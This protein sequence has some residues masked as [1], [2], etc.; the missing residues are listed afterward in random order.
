MDDIQVTQATET[1]PN[2]LAIRV[3]VGTLVLA[4]DFQSLGVRFVGGIGTD[5][6]EIF[7]DTMTST[8]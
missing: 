3:C 4:T 8:S 2:Q 7:V 1:R 5:Q 6:Y